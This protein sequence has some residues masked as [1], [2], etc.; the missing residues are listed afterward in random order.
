MLLFLFFFYC[1]PSVYAKRHKEVSSISFK[2]SLS[3][4]MEIGYNHINKLFLFYSEDFSFIHFIFVARL[5]ISCS[6]SF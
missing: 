1:P 5:F 2:N 4:R 6:Y 3:N